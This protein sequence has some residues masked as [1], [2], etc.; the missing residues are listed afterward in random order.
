MF[1]EPELAPYA[2]LFDLMDVPGLNET[3]N[4]LLKKLFSLFVYNIQFCFF[5]FDTQQYHNSITSFNYVKSLFKE[6]ENNIITNSIFIFNKYDLATDKELT[7]QS[8]KIFLNDSLKINKN[9]FIH[10]SSEQ[11]LLNI[12]KYENFLSYTEYI[13]NQAPLPDNRTSDEHIRLNMQKD[14]N[15]EI[16]E[17]LDDSNDILSEDQKIEYKIFEG[18]MEQITNFDSKLDIQDYFYYKKIF[19]TNISDIKSSQIE[20]IDNILIENI[21]KSCNIT[22]KSYIDFD[23]FT[24]L[25]EDILKD[26]GIENDQINEIKRTKTNVQNRN[27]LSLKRK[28]I[29]ILDSLKEILIKIKLLKN[30]DYIEN[31]YKDCSFFEQFMRKEIKIRI[32]TI[33]CYSSGKSSLINSIIGNNILPVSSE[34]ST[35]VGIIIKYKLNLV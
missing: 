31:I 5:I 27:I 7:L 20:V 19:K 9:D 15:I 1:N 22:I 30:H 6:N 24:N 8:F 4:S 11:L 18:K 23:K 10:C 2:N 13:F 35:N 26:L 14:F 28:P 17:N 32:P 21:I 34:I 29:E 33:G 12:F 25:M 16:K 3:N